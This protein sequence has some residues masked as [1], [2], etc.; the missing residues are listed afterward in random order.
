VLLA[1]WHL[2]AAAG[3]NSAERMDGDRPTQVTNTIAATTGAH[4]S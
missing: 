3:K 2:E 1:Q 4:K